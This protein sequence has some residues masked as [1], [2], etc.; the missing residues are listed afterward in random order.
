MPNKWTRE[1]QKQL[2]VE[3]KNGVSL[4]EIAKKHERTVVAIEVRIQ[5]IVYDAIKKKGTSFDKLAEMTGQTKR[6]LLEYYKEY[7]EF[8]ENNKI[9][10]EQQIKPDNNNIKEQNGGSQE[11]SNKLKKSDMSRDV[12]KIKKLEKLAY[13][14]TVENKI[15]KKVIKNMS[16]GKK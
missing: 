11:S 8:M 15:L 3:L 16:R 12:K 4:E 6:K 2:I 1:E 9:V 10:P 14:L 13:K 5:K 7:Q